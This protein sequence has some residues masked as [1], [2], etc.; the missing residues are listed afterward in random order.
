MR[1]TCRTRKI[2]SILLA[3]AMVSAVTA[4]CKSGG[5]NGDAVA[6]ND[7]QTL[8]FP[9]KTPVTLTI[10]R[11]AISSLL[12][13]YPDQSK[14]PIY[15][16]LTKKTGIKFVLKCPAVGQ[17]KDQF[18]LMVASGEMPDIFDGNSVSNYY[19]GG[20]IKAGT[21]G[22]IMKLNDLQKKYA[23]DLLK[24]YEK[25]KGVDAYAKN[26]DGDYLGIPFIRGAQITT[27]TGGMVMRKDWLDKLGLQAPTTI[28]EWYDAL[29]AFKNK[30]GATAP[31]LDL[32]QQLYGA[33]GINDGYFVEDGK[34]KFGP[35]DPR[36]KDFLTE[37][38][39][40]YKEGLID[41]EIATN[42]SKTK[43]AK[44]C[45]NKSG[46]FYGTGGNG[47]GRYEHQMASVDPNYKLIGVQSPTLKEGDIN[48]I[49]QSDRSVAT[50]ITCSISSK[51]KNPDVAMS[52]LNY[53]FTG[54]GYI[55]YNFGIEGQTFNWENDY[56]KFTDLITK[57]P[58]DLSFT[59]A[60]QLYARSA[61][62]GPFVQDPR[63]RE[64][65]FALPEQQQAVKSW[66]TY[67]ENAQGPDFPYLRGILSL[68]ESSEITPI[69]TQVNTYVDEMLYKFVEGQT[70][71]T[72]G[73]FNSYL[74]QLKNLG[75]DTAVKDRQTAEDR[76]R[77][78][79]PTL[80]TSKTEIDVYDMYKDITQ[81]DLTK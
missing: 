69:E 16:E 24:V 27:T 64:Q 54:D 62:N 15:E 65:Y 3:A 7:D 9:L 38:A 21:D 28:S 13:Q 32:G 23:P 46:A 68:S 10:W 63:Y 12:G 18:N 42:N 70:Q 35:A 37:M 50:M 79:N 33:Y 14:L 20:L 47:I 45:S 66:R 48:R 25:Y 19:P 51:C 43:D 6:A 53:G 41:P 61:E 44:A 34:V 78:A 74:A 75:L 58:Q 30:L 72:D 22:I 49:F 56:P 11:P 57:N 26:S 71:I 81:K 77:K 36:Y 31:L 8:T 55:L 80:Y 2:I 59:A 29:S 76:F 4:G 52:F 60:L 1:K 40:W 73:T 5:G 39:K 17:E 67:A